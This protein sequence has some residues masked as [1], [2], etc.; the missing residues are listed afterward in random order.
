MS[1]SVMENDTIAAISTGLTAAGISVIRVSGPDA[2]C[3][4][5]KI[6]RVK[7]QG[8]LQ[9]LSIAG[10]DSHTVHYGYIVG[11]DETIL[12]EV[13]MLVLKAPRTFTREDTIEIDCHG[14][15]VVT[16]RILRRV[17]EAG[18]RPAEPGEFTKRAFLNGRIDLS[19]AEAVID[20]I[21]SKNELALKNSV[22][23]LNGRVQTEIVEIREKLLRQVARIEAA[24]DDPE[25]MNLDG[26]SDEL[27]SENAGHLS[28]IKALL[29][30][31]DRGRLLKEGIRTVIVGKPNA[32]K[33]SLMN[34]LLRYERAI[35]TDI[36]GT[37]RDTLV[38]EVNLDGITL[39]LVDTAGI[40]ETKDTVEQIGV[41]RAKQELLQADL[42]LFVTDASVKLST[43][44]RDI[45]AEILATKE[46][47]GA[48][49]LAILNKCDLEMV[50][51]EE[52]L[53]NAVRNGM[54]NHSDAREVLREGD[55]D[56]VSDI[57]V[58]SV[59]VKEVA[60]IE[61]IEEKI[62]SILFAGEL[63]NDDEV[64]ITAERHRSLLSQAEESLRK[65]QDSVEMGMPED[66]YTID[67]MAAYVS[68]GQIL[69]EELDEDLVDCIFREF[70]M[71]K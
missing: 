49:V 14:G 25:H 26:Y 71:G 51:T 65:V 42:I 1:G 35:V 36:A 10:V 32:G 38:E 22:K 57:E 62:K 63:R 34:A 8:K 48:K 20:V 54:R 61:K 64:I 23:Q 46:N 50:T 5:E 41:D 3:V 37:T 53:Q 12:D 40:R 9:K 21:N 69:G 24:L 4:A 39:Q 6:F 56:R 43:E 67:L 18:S 19:Q 11:E 17:L 33:S 27:L 28:K 13:M 70:C 66:F 55:S 59:S 16:R 58:L 47:S 30:T 31:A 2:F 29:A 60:G 44:D 7:N 15:I 45:L 52:H 68:L